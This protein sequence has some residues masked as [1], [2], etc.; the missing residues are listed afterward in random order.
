MNYPRRQQF[1]RLTHAAEAGTASAAAA[2]FGLLT[3]AP[4]LQPPPRCYCWRQLASHSTPATGY[5][6][7]GAAV[8]VLARRAR[9]GAVS[10][11]SRERGGGCGTRCRGEAE[12]TSTPWPS[13][14]PGSRSPSRR[15]R[16]AT[17]VTASRGYAIRRCGCRGG[18]GGGAGAAPCPSAWS[19]SSR[20]SWSSRSTGRSRLYEV[21]HADA[22]RTNSESG[23]LLRH[24]RSRERACIGS[25]A[26]GPD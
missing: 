6:L 10:R 26:P 19:G 20:T 1:R 16:G 14:R 22:S 24:G 2:L 9:Y 17:T 11:S 7:R 13:R 3:A 5:R 12:G 8:W 4:A 18:V 21:A 15:R 23:W 25:L